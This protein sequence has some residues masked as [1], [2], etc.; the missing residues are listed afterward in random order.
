MASLRYFWA[1]AAACT[2]A[3]GDASDPTN[4]RGGR[5]DMGGDPTLPGSPGDTSPTA[6]QP[7]QPVSGAGCTG[8]HGDASRAVPAGVDPMFSAAPPRGTKGETARTARAVGAHLA[9]LTGGSVASPIKCAECHVVP[10]AMNHSNGTVDLAFGPLAKT[11]NVTPSW[12]GT[13]CAASYC[14]GNFAGGTTAAAPD[15]TAGAM[16][17]TSCHGA[18]PNTGDHRRGDHQVAC[19]TCH[20]TGYSATTVN[21]ALHVNGTRNAGGPGSTITWNPATRSCTPQCHGTETW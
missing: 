17:C 5:A 2:L 21:A 1:I 12:N 20:G 4:L 19:S 18:P 8:C 10:T 13:T 15:W 6:S 16:T 9:H 11:G 14:H 3:C 7:S